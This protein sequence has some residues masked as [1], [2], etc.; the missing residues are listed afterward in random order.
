[1]CYMIALYDRKPW[2]SEISATTSWNKMWRN[3]HMVRFPYPQNK[4]AVFSQ[5]ACPARQ[6]PAVPLV[7]HT[8]PWHYAVWQCPSLCYLVGWNRGHCNITYIHTYI[9]IHLFTEIIKK[10]LSLPCEC[11]NFAW[12]MCT[13]A[14]LGLWDLATL[15]LASASFTSWI[16]V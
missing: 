1:M 6:P 7:W 10:C 11:S 8:I 15:K 4:E 2:C 14:K 16:L 12:A 9:H 5:P 13:N 3:T